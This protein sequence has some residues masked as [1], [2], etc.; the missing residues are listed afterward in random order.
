MTGH[1]VQRCWTIEQIV[2]IP[3]TEDPMWNLMKIDQ[4]VS[5]KRRFKD[6]VSLYMYIAQGQGQTLGDK[7]LIVTIGVCYFDHTL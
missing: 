2:N 7:I 6:Y 4:A 3:S 5:E 1:L